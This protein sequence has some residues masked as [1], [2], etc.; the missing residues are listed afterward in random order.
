MSVIGHCDVCAQ[1]KLATEGM[2]KSVNDPCSQWLCFVCMQSQNVDKQ[3]DF[4]T[5]L[6]T[7]LP[8]IRSL[9]DELQT[10]DSLD[11]FNTS[12]IICNTI[13]KLN[14]IRRFVEK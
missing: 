14:D 12:N 7:M 6:N 8:E 13:G 3:A 4:Q 11:V 1:S 2:F 9:V 10:A 5:L